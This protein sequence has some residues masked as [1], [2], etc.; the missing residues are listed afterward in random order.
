MCFC[1]QRF[2]VIPAPD[3][4]ALIASATPL[5]AGAG[6]GAGAGVVGVRAPVTVRHDANAHIKALIALNMDYLFDE[7]A[8]LSI[9]EASLIAYRR[10]K[11]AMVPSFVINHFL[12]CLPVN[13]WYHRLYSVLSTSYGIMTMLEERVMESGLKDLIVFSKNRI[14]TLAERLQRYQD[15]LIGEAPPAFLTD[16]LRRAALDQSTL[17]RLSDVISS[18]VK[19]KSTKS[20]F[21]TQTAAEIQDLFSRQAIA[22][23]MRMA[24]TVDKPWYAR[25]CCW[26]DSPSVRP[27]GVEMTG[28]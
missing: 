21:T 15:R 22:A 12:A 8:S 24:P 17:V 13:R 2:A 9:L 5:R 28:V 6:T 14:W 4:D 20:Y 10:S 18:I 1:A 16:D 3:V 23:G 26:S 7:I 19:L 27:E 25:L 11:E